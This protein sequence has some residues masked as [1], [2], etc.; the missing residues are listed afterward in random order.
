MKN[1][2]ITGAAGTVGKKVLK[3]LLVEG[4]YNITAVDL[5]TRHNKKV[6]RK[7]RKRI[8]I[9]YA[10]ITNDRKF[11][12]L[13]KNMDYVIHLA[14]VMPPLADLNQKLSYEGDYKGTEIIVRVLN[15]YNQKCHL[16]Y[17]SSASVYGLQSNNE[18][19]VSTKCNESSLGYYAKNKLDS[20][21]IIKEKLDNY[22]IYRLPIVLSNPNDENYIFMY[23]PKSEFEIIT[24]EDAGY[25]FS[26]AIDKVKEVN[27]KTFN[28][29]GGK[30][31]ITTG[32]KLNNELL[33]IYG[34]NSKYIKTKLFIEKNF[35]TFVFKDSDKLEEI[36]SFRNDSIDSYFL[37]QKRKGKKYNLRRLIAKLFIRK[38]K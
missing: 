13:L 30:N 34:I 27:K 26:R 31:S 33:K 12:E 29:G 37:R 28:V 23:N 24:D 4:K 18:V 10:D 38:E 9:I 2:L 15:F 25:M 16:L 3:Y 21:N 36:L 5:K 19:S 17:A 35:Y 11:E 8:N 1:V 14:G 7:Y 6:L 20:E 32:K 22:S